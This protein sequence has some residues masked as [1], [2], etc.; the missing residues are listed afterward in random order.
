MKLH[1]L[2]NEELERLEKDLI[3]DSKHMMDKHKG[4][5]ASQKLKL[6]R[7]EMERRR[8]PFGTIVKQIQRWFGN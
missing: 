4:W 6:V 7:A 3:F 2:R 1:E 8:N 5:E